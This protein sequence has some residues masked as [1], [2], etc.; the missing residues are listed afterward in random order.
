MPGAPVVALC[1]SRQEHH[2]SEQPDA[3]YRPAIMWLRLARAAGLFQML[4][5]GVS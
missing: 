5:S 4:A 1:P 2:L 3:R